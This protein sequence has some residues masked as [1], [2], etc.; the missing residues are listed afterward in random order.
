MQLLREH[1]L[2][3]IAAALPVFTFDQALAQVENTLF[4]GYGTE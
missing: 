4:K 3:A 2:L 1:L